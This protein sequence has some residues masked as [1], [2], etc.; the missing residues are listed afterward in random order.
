MLPPNATPFEQA[1]LSATPRDLPVD[2]Q[3]LWDPYQCP[4]ALLPHLAQA[5]SVNLWD[6]TWTSREK[7]AAIDAAFFVHQHKG[8]VAAIRRAIKPFAHLIR[9]EEWFEVGTDPHTFRLILSVFEEGLSYAFYN[10]MLALIDDAKPLRSHLLEIQI[11]QEIPSAEHIGIY[12]Y[13]GDTTT[14]YPKGVQ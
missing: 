2:L 11:Y 1:C 3:Q 9:I 8:T 14:I 12:T 13:S 7:R 10:N 6:P 4:E 5:L